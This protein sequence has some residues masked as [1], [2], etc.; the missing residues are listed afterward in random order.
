MARRKLGDVRE[1]ESIAAAAVA[2]HD[3]T[4]GALRIEVAEHDT[5]VTATRERSHAHELEIRRT[6]QQIELNRQQIDVL[7][8]RMTELAQELETLSARREPQRLRARGTARPCR[9]WRAGVD[10]G[11]VEPRVGERRLRPRITRD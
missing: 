4:L 10:S 2:E 9:S 1:R 11:R 6:E 8:T 7:G 5:Q 3:N